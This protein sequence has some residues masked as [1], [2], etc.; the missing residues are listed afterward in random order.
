MSL[1]IRPVY[2]QATYRLVVLLCD[3]IV[4]K[5][6]SKTSWLRVFLCA[7][8][9]ARVQSKLASSSDTMFVVSSKVRKNLV[10]NHVTQS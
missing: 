9:V 10:V 3:Q 5:V 8:V 4:A 1:S 2:D 6:Q 7:Q